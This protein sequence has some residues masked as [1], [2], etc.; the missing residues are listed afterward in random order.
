MVLLITELQLLSLKILPFTALKPMVV[1]EAM[2]NAVRLLLKGQPIG[3]E[4]IV[5]DVGKV[6]CGAIGIGDRHAARLE[7]ADLLLDRKRGLGEFHR[8]APV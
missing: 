7:K 4:A 1:L 2:F 8:Q 3:P 5:I 6:A